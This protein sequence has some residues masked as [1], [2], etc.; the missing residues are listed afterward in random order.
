MSITIRDFFSLGKPS[1]VLCKLVGT[2][3][4]YKFEVYY[5]T[6]GVYIR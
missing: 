3:Q 1:T 5:Y 6:Y 2:A 4:K